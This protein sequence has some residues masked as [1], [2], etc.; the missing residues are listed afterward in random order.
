MKQNCFS[1]N[2]I[3]GRVEHNFGFSPG[4]QKKTESA[5]RFFLGLSWAGQLQI[6]LFAC[7]LFISFAMAYTLPTM[8]LIIVSVDVCIVDVVSVCHDSSSTY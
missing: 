8:P 7:F 6:F 5:S 3:H 1:Y 2:C 4:K